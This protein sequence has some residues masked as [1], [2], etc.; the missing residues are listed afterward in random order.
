MSI[1]SDWY[2]ALNQIIFCMWMLFIC[3][4]QMRLFVD[5]V[6]AETF[7]IRIV[8]KEEIDLL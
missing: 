7:Y 5:G 3:V 2:A 8:D 4:A 1:L 6:S